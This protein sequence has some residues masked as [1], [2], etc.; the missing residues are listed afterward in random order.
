MVAGGER[1]GGRCDLGRGHRLV[2][3]WHLQGSR[4]SWRAAQFSTGADDDRTSH[5]RA[6]EQPSSSQHRHRLYH[7]LHGAS[8]ISIS[9]RRRRCPHC[10]PTKPRRRR[11]CRRRL[12]DDFGRDTLPRR[13]PLTFLPEGALRAALCP[14]TPEPHREGIR[15]GNPPRGF[16]RRPQLDRRREA[17]PARGDTRTLRSTLC[18]FTK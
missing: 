14:A 16:S 8:S 2:A 15:E 9:R 5:E 17:D 18:A 6:S 4:G 7:P 3:P 10:V 12:Q 13:A 11:H 1:G